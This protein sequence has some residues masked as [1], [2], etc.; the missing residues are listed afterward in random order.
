VH[1]AVGAA[2]EVPDQ[3]ALHG[4]EQHLAAFGAFA[5]SGGVVEHPADAG[6]GEVGGQGQAGAFGDQVGAGRVPHLLHQALG[7][8][9]LPDDG[10]SG[11]QAGE[12]VPQDGGLALVGDAGGGDLAGGDGG[13]GEGLGGDAFQ[14]APDLQGVVLDPAGFG[15]VLAVLALRDRHQPPV[16]VEQDAAG[17][18][19]A[20]VDG[21]DIPLSHG[22]SLWADG[23]R[24]PAG[25]AQVA[26]DGA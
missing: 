19:G 20:L 12:A 4:A 26:G 24:S 5:Q 23:A 14:V 21:H 17:G 11:G 9:V 15:E 7:A 2:G 16:V 22:A 25:G 13:L 6:R 10:A 18:G 1:A 8:G 3:P